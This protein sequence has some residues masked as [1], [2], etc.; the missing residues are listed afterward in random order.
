M[1]SNNSLRRNGKYRRSMRQILGFNFYDVFVF[2][3]CIVF[4]LVCVYPM[5]YVLVASVTPYEEYIKG[6]LMLWP[7]GGVDLQYY[8]AIFSTKSFTNS[9]WISVSKTVIATVLS[10]LVTASMAYGVSKV[11][12]KGMKVINALVVFN[13]FFTGGLIPQYI[14]YQNLGLLRNYW[15]MVIP[16]ALNITYFIIM[17]NY[18]SYSVPK[19]LEEAALLDGC[20]DIGVLF[21]IMLPISKPAITTVALFYAVDHWNDFFS[22]IMYINSRAKWPLQLFLRSMLF[23]N[24]AAY[25]GSGESLFLLGQPMKMAAVMLAVIPIMCAYPFFQKYFTKGV[26]MGAV[27]G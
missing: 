6:G 11:H 22:A 21:R 24:D 25:S 20:T 5:W 12:V 26:M 8:K 18:Y 4:A 14:L 13:L 23:E 7:T 19:S 17:R 9:M 2:L 1:R 3:F 16:G 27:K 10:V 15:V